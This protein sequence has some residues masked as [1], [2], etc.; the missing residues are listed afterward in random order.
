MT[1]KTSD[2][3]FDLPK[4]LIAQHPTR[5]R[6]Q[7]RLMVLDRI[8]G[9]RSHSMV[10]ELPAI[11]GGADFLS[12]HGGAPLIVFNDSKVRKARLIGKCEKTGSLAEFLLLES[13]GGDTWK[14]MVKKAARKKPGERY[15]FTDDAGA[16]IA[17]AQIT[18][19]ATGGDFRSIRFDRL[20]DDDWLD[21]Y[22]H[23]PLPP[24]IKR[25]AVGGTAAGSTAASSSEDSGDDAARYQTVYA[26]NT[27]SVAAPTAGLHFTDEILGELGARGIESAF[28]TLHVGA[29]TFL[30]VR[31]QN[32]EDHVMHAE[33][34]VISEESAAKIESAKA[35]NRK[36]IAV[37]TTCIRCLESAWSDGAGLKKGEQ[38][39][40][41]YIYPSFR[42]KV[43]D[44]LFTNFHTPQ[45]T[46]IMLVSAFASRELIL[47]SYQEAVTQGY[48]F[49]SYGDAM[50]IK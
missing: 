39:T 14:V 5:E 19:D 17:A 50:L 7:S 6:G 45:S 42:F 29:G 24:Y 13:E 44:A 2:F 15:V 26:K 20:I 10:A 21:R 11:L 22:G 32:I 3:N 8:T 47:E 30:P 4:E 38:T 12:P 9:G 37:G 16:E 27:G 33:R 31:A 25:D 43:A 18:G 36:I 49:F 35:E 23:V 1:M 28:I 48:R 40:S 41:I 34:F 46:L